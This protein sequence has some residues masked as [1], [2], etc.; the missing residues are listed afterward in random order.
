M[1]VDA[2]EGFA[3]ATSF[4]GL[5]NVGVGASFLVATAPAEAKAQFGPVMATLESAAQA[6]APRGVTLSEKVEIAGSPALKALYKGAQVANG[7]AM[8][9]WVGYYEAEQVVLV[10]YQGPQGALESE[11]IAATFASIDFGTPATLEEKLA[12]LPFVLGELGDMRV[13]DVI[14]QSGVLLTLGEKD[15]DPEGMQPVLIVVMSLGENAGFPEDLGAFSDS[16]LRRVE[17]IEIDGD[18][19][20]AEASVAGLPGFR[21]EAAAM[22]VGDATPLRV[23]QW[24]GF[25]DGRYV[26][27][28]GRSRAD[29]WEGAAPNFE[30]VVQ[31]LAFR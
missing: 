8:E 3:P 19:R 2:P 30:T 23:V 20:R 22:T 13:I 17:R 27:V 15:V 26:R 14:S 5:Q 6:M 10:T 31:G 1:S 9:K 12:A 16:L 4:S 18:I 7:E 25:G 29:A 28:V 24:M 21:S 11:K